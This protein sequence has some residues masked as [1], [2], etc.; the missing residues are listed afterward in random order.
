MEDNKK[1]L[2]VQEILK[3]VLESPTLEIE[4]N[5]KLEDIPNLESVSYMTA[6]A[7]IESEYGMQFDFDD[8]SNFKTIGE[9]LKKIK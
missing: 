5:T 4:V 1:L 9:L 6:I 7:L 2:T 8:I 3:D